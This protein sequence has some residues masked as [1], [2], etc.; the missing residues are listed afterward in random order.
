MSDINAAPVAQLIKDLTTIVTLAE[1]NGTLKRLKSVAVYFDEAELRAIIAALSASH[2]E[3]GRDWK[4]LDNLEDAA[5][6]AFKIL[7]PGLPYTAEDAFWYRQ[8]A[9]A[10]LERC[11]P[12]AN[13]EQALLRELYEW[14][15]GC[16]DFRVDSN[17][18]RRV[19]SVLRSQPETVEFTDVERA[20]VEYLSADG[21]EV[22]ERENEWIAHVDEAEISVTALAC[23]I[24]SGRRK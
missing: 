6:A 14:C 1:K 15:R 5:E 11:S 8:V 22:V 23:A 10:V 16:N 20:A 17:L 12:A 4:A 24:Y 2:A 18:A 9:H 3:G 13:G 19:Q 7:S 21:F